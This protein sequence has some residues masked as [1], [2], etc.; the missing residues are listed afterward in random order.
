MKTAITI[1]IVFLVILVLLTGFWGEVSTTILP[2]TTWGLYSRDFFA[3]FLAALHGNIADFLVVGIILYWFEQRRLRQERIASAKLKKDLRIRSN[4]DALED[5]SHYKGDDASYRTMT[6][7]KRLAKLGVTSISTTNAA[8]ADQIIRELNLRGSKLHGADFT[9]ST[10]EDVDFQDAV[11]EAANFTEA[12]LKRVHFANAK[13]PRAKF[14]EASLDGIDF[15]SSTI[16]SAKFDNASLR[17]AIFSNV[18]CKGISFDGADLTGANFLG[19]RN[20][21]PRA[22]EL[23]K[24]AKTTQHDHK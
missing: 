12:K 20:L 21:S 24:R 3:N 16:V 13:L 22:I 8:L 9:G 10:L 18:D 17:S 7:I 15:R 23:I 19:A 6:L 5:L 4:E 11:L 14:L 1:F 2:N